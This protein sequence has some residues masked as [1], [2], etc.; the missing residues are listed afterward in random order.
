M[1]VYRRPE[2]ESDRPVYDE[3]RERYGEDPAKRLEKS[4]GVA[5]ERIAGIDD[6]GLLAAYRKVEIAEYGGRVGVIAALDRRR[7]ELKDGGSE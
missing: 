5:R 2:S 4:V 1:S 6:L 3:F 7:D